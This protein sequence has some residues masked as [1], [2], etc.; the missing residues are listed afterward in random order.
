MSTKLAIGHLR[1]VEERRKKP[2]DKTKE[3]QLLLTEV[4]QMR[5]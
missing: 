1:A 2:S 5:G 3:G 4:E